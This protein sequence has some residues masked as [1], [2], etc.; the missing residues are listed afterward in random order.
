MSSLHYIT[1]AAGTG[2]THALADF[3]VKWFDNNVLAKHQAVLAIT[4]MHGARK[5][6]RERLNERSISARFSIS[7][8]DSFALQIINRW[9]LTFGYS[10]PI[11]PGIEGAFTKDEIGY[12]AT[13]EEIMKSAAD[14]SASPAVAKT[15][16]NSFP[17]ILIDEFQD[18]T[19]N[20]LALI[21]NLRNYVDLILAADPFQALDGNESACKWALGFE[22]DESVKFTRLEGSRRTKCSYI[23]DAA[24]ALLENRCAIYRRDPLPVFFAPTYNVATWKLLP[25]LT[26]RNVTAA[27]IY[28]AHSVLVNLT[29]SV[30]RQSDKRIAEGKKAIRFPWRTQMSDAELEKQACAEFSEA[31]Q[32]R[33]WDKNMTWRKLHEQAQY[34]SKAK[35]YNEV[36]EKLFGYVVTSFIHSRKFVA[37]RPNKFEATTVHGAKNRE[38]DHVYVIWDNNLCT[39]ID[40]DR[41]RR[42]LYNAITRASISCRVIAIGSKNQIRA[43]PVLSLLG[44]PK[45]SL[46][47]KLR[48]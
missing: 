43:C 45:D 39:K 46:G 1:G 7:T 44:E 28:P 2:K 23:L 30:K 15:V 35:G 19:D 26:E 12:R 24:D 20:Q 33:T 34:I 29:N 42:L 40:D 14:I 18:C 38:F 21:R 32:Q 4:R 6:L 37:V 27:L 10:S 11:V 47:T 8:V 9:R 41:K 31:R 5:R 17:I 13:F 25:K 3:L 36:P 22:G 16:A 48:K